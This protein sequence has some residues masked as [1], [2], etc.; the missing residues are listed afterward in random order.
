MSMKQDSR[1]N[2]RLEEIYRSF[3]VISPATEV[4]DINLISNSTDLM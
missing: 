2:S 3:L 4:F 1:M